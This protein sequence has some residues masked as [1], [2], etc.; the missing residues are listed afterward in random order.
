MRKN[1]RKYGL[2]ILIIILGYFTYSYI[3]KKIILSPTEVELSE[4]IRLSSPDM[5]VDAIVW[6][7]DVGATASTSYEVYILPKGSK[8]IKNQ[9]PLFIADHVEKIN[10]SWREQGCLEI[11]YTKARIFKFTNFWE[12]KDVL[13]YL[14]VVELRLSPSLD[15]WSLSEDDRKN[16]EPYLSIK[17]KYSK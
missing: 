12:S 1:I 9:E 16:V 2:F 5:V 13:D 4:V 17:R 8:E 3:K 14:Y 11:H 10:I 15:L 6:T 7:R